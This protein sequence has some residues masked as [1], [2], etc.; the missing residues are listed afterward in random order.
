MC[1]VG[2]LND[3]GVITGPAGYTAT[4]SQQGVQWPSWLHSHLV[5]IRHTQA[6]VVCRCAG[7]ASCEG[8]MWAPNIALAESLLVCK[9]SRQYVVLPHPKCPCSSPNLSM[10]FTQPVHA[11][12]PTCPCSS[13]NLSMQFTQPDH[14]VLLPTHGCSI[15]HH[16]L[17]YSRVAGSDFV[18][19]STTRIGLISWYGGFM[20]ASSISVIPALQTSAFGWMVRGEVCGGGIVNVKL[21]SYTLTHRVP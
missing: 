5:T 10:Q 6:C 19:L 13:P 18:I 2:Q 11:V 12:H 3:S 1:G 9:S 4:W 8:C 14:A 21:V 17:G 20:S 16:R 15:S 7:R